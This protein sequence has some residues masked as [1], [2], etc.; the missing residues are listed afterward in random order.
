[1]LVQSA[2]FWNEYVEFTA[3]TD[4]KNMC[5]GKEQLLTALHNVFCRGMG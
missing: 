5:P 2:I 4:S 1:M 3:H